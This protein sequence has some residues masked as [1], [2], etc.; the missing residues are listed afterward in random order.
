MAVTITQIQPSD[1]IASSRLTI[2]SN[3]SALKA[4]IDSVQLLLNP[5][6]ATLSGVKSIAVN[7]AAV[8]LTQNIF[9]VGKGSSLLGNVIMGTTGASTSVT[10]NG[11]GGL[12]ISQGTI[13][14]A[15]ITN[16]G[17]L[18]TSSL[19][20]SGENRQPGVATAF[21]SSSIVGLTVS[22]SVSVAGLKYLV[23]RN[24]GT[25]SGLT[26]SIPTGST[27]QVVEFFHILGPSAF[28]VSIS[29]TNFV[30]LTGGIMMTRT[31]DT[32]KC[33]YDGSKWY[34]WNYSPS[35]FATGG[36]SSSITFTTTTI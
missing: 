18:S 4:G 12:I 30:G 22:K 20:V 3:F 9:T 21:S 36:T 2:N 15:N 10:I 13:T 33:V 34:M 35:S 1:A 31:G 32:L 19:S 5:T 11:T 23:V 7:D 6:T 14:S 17:I 26:A 25:A 28:P 24:D 8:S 16:V 29:T 27:G